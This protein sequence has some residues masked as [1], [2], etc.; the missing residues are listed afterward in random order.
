MKD[1]C[2]SLLFTGLSI[3]GS[4]DLEG[5][6]SGNKPRDM[7]GAPLQEQMKLRNLSF[8]ECV[9]ALSTCRAETEGGLLQDL[10]ESMQHK[11]RDSH[12]RESPRSQISTGVQPERLSGSLED[13]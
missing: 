3:W 11:E 7:Q 13:F 5:R 9:L 6:D 2:D 4:V 12:A 8:S 10:L 1:S